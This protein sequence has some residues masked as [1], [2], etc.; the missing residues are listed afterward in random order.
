MGN[1]ARGNKTPPSLPHPGD[2][3][4]WEQEFVIDIYTDRFVEVKPISVLIRFL[5]GI[6]FT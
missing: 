1:T 2:D 5:T 3:S 4:S 6:H